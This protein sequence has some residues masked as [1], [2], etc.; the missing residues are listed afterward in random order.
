MRLT[1][2]DLLKFGSVITASSTLDG[3]FTPFG[4]FGATLAEALSPDITHGPRSGKQI[5]LTFHGAGA[6][7]LDGKLLDIFKSTNTPISVFA[8]GS[9]LKANPNL[10]KRVVDEGHDIAN[11]TMNHYQMKTLSA[12]KVDSEISGC[13]KELTK[14]VG[15]QGA[16]FRPS[17]TQY[18]NAII[19]KAAIKHGYGACISYDVD[20]MDYTDPGAKAV[21]KNVISHLRGGSIVSLH[22]GH[23]NTLDVMPGLLDAIHAKGY[24]PVTLTTLLKK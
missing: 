13:A 11:H 6:S 18:S 20:S 5:A 16:W 15:N 24:T 17:G 23:Q 19:R 7:S 21:H 22:F 14:L 2:R 4:G 10:A 8:I 3:L 12:A 1:R 9:W